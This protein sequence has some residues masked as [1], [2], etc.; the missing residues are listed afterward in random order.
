MET[1]ISHLLKKSHS[2]YVR[3]ASK[4]SLMSTSSAY[5]VLDVTLNR[6]LLLKSRLVKRSLRKMTIRNKL[7]KKRNKTQQNC[8]E[9]PEKTLSSVSKTIVDI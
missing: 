8:M 9:D 7:Q 3:N 4:N 2:T 1:L 6:V 5:M